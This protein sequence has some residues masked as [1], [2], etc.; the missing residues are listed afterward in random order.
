M[1]NA[2]LTSDLTIRQAAAALGVSA[3]TLRYYEREGLVSV[4]RQASGERLYSALALQRLKFL[5]HLRGTGMNMQG[6]RE[7]VALVEQG[8]DTL[9]E[10]LELLR[11]HEQAVMHQLEE[12]EKHLVGI[13]H[14]IAN[15]DR[16]CQKHDQMCQKETA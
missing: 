5:I 8:E 2:V 4:P 13:R 15:Y 7:Y 10:R 14:K 11:Q 3:H 6:L 1:P 9:A 16:I 12:L